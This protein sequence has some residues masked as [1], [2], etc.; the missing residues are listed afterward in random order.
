MGFKLEV[1]MPVQKL[2]EYLDSEGVRYM[3]I[4]HSPAFTAQEIAAAAHVRGEEMAKTVIV[5]VD[6]KL[7]MVV[8]P[9]AQKVDVALLRDRAGARKVEIATESDFSSTFPECELGAMPPFGNLYG[10]DVY[11]ASRLAEDD[12]IVFNAGSHIELIRLPYADFER[13]VKPKVL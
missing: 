13:L 2:K 8:L 4:T 12:E 5:K 6:G 3:V 7:A 1:F 10:I 11:V 9:A